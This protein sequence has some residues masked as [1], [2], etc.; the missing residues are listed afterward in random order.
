MYDDRSNI[1]I[2]GGLFFFSLMFAI[3]AGALHALEVNL[4]W[5]QRKIYAA[6]LNSK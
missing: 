3:V 6:E 2:E 4:F 1:K 5:I